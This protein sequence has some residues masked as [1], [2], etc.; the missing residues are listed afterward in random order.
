MVADADLTPTG[1]ALLVTEVLDGLG[2]EKADVVGVDTGG[3]ITQ[4]LMAQHRDRVDRVVITACDA[5]D[6]FP[7]RSLR[8]AVAMV[9]LPVVLWLTAQGARLRVLRRLGNHSSLTHAGVDDGTLR[10]WTGPLR[11]R[12]IRRDL[13]KVLRHMQPCYTVAA[14]EANRDFPRPVLIAWGDDDRIFPRRLGEQ[15][16]EDLP[17]ARLVTVPD[18]AAFAALDQP[19]A[20]AEL[21]D[22]HL[23]PSPE[24]PARRAPMPAR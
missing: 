22:G 16:A 5:Y 21:I 3:A 9:R 6:E 19:E 15:M 1:L 17:H 10:Q 12:A 13:A 18:C 11:S 14:A 20:L 8:A 4:L 23:T 7:P 2:V 24:P